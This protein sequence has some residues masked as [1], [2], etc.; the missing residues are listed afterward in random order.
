MAETPVKVEAA[1]APTSPAPL[2]FKAVVSS[3]GKHT[4]AVFAVENL[5]AIVEAIVAFADSVSLFVD[6][7]GI[8]MRVL[9]KARIALIEAVLPRDVFA[10]FSTKGEGYI[11]VD[12]KSFLAVLRRAKGKKVELEYEDGR[13]TVSIGERS[14]RIRTLDASAE[15]VP[16]PKTAHTVF[17]VIDAELFR[18]ALVDARVIRADAAQLVALN[19]TLTFKAV[20]ETKEVEVRLGSAEGSASSTYALDYL[21]KAAKAFDGVVEV[22]FGNNTPLE[23][24]TTFNE[25][26]VKVYV[27]PR[28]E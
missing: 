22:K 19:G 26:Y 9:D 13:L 18:E 25:G 2:R 5:K 23:L 16:Q 12:T 1:P 17:A 15:E 8:K 27:A 24:S 21:L 28:V 7:N 14:F 11:T 10:E 20:N 6:S 4:N 3:G